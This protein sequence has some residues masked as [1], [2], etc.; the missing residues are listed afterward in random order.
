MPVYVIGHR[1]PDTDSICAAI[2]YAHFLR[3]AHIPDAVAACCGE[4]NPRTHFVLKE[5]GLEHPRLLMDVHPT[6]GQL[7]NRDVVT[8]RENE[9]FFAVYRR[10][11]AHRLHAMPVVD[12]R[13]GLTGMLSLSRLLELLMPDAAGSDSPRLV[14]TTLEHIRQA[15]SGTF[16]HAVDP[17]RVDALV[18]SV[19]AM[20]CENFMPRLRERDPGQTLIVVGDRPTIQRPTIQFGAR[21]LVVTGGHGLAPDLLEEA[22]AKGVTVIGSPLDTASTAMMI[23]GA[24][25]I[26]SAVDRTFRKY[27]EKHLARSVRKEVH[28]LNQELFPVVGEGGDLLGVFTKEDLASPEPVRLVLVDHNELAQAVSGAEEAEIL[29]VMDHHRV[30][31]GLISRAPIRFQNDTVGSTCTM[32][33]RCFRREAMAPPTGI[34][35]CMAAGIISDTLNLSSPT[36]TP[37]DRDMLAWLGEA[38]GFDVQAFAE[39]FFAMGSALQ[40]STPRAALR[41]DCK[42]YTEGPWNLAVAQIEEVGFEHFERLKP[43]LA[44]ELEILAREKRLAFACLLVTDISL[45][46]SLLLVAGQEHLIEAIDYPRLESNLFQ[47]DSVVS[48][49]K[50]LLPHLARQFARVVVD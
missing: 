12:A 29:E 10:M 46:N 40:L 17:H 15:F 4:V 41:M 50:Q 9:P 47:L 21:C 28:P 39:A 37:V 19:G 3:N 30:G 20:S 34:A 2:S 16:L 11:Q 25:I 5:A 31:G 23:R 44:E 38:G 26:D 33:A 1:N 48:R 22:R 27:K 35:K 14:R 18:L 8:A 49:K 42:E 43:V 7:C 45:N 24:K 32:V 36:T 13:G 6:V